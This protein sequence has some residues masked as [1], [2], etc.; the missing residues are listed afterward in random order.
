MK[1]NL[2]LPPLPLA[3]R[4]SK[5]NKELVDTWINGINTALDQSDRHT[6]P[7]VSHPAI[8]VDAVIPAATTSNGSIT[9]KFGKAAIYEIVGNPYDETAG[10][11]AVYLTDQTSDARRRVVRI[12]NDWDREFAIGDHLHITPW[13]SGLW[14]ISSAGCEA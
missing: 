1:N 3:V 14:L 10:S 4:G 5:I 12:V 2:A 6:P 7:A 13:H 8:V 11:P 9:L